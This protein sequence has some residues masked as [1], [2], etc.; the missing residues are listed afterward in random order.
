MFLLAVENF[1]KLISVGIVLSQ[2]D[3]FISYF[4]SKTF[5]RL[6]LFFSHS[7]FTNNVIFI[8]FRW[9]NFVLLTDYLTFSFTNYTKQASLEKVMK[10]F[11]ELF[12][13]ALK[14]SS[15]R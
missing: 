14:S 12:L 13:F 7:S 5:S 6:P 11:A 2:L 3:F 15:R 9:Y 8:I 10:G 4:N 1:V